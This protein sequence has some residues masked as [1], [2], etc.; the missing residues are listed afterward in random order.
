[1]KTSRRDAL[2]AALGATS[3]ALLGGCKPLARLSRPDERLAELPKVEVDPL[4]RLAN[5]I[6][7]GPRPGDLSLINSL[8]HAEFIRRQL[9]A[10][11]EEDLDVKVQLGR[12]DIYSVAAKELEDLPEAEIISQLHHGAIYRAVFSKNQLHERMVDFWTNHFNLYAKKG[13]TAYRV[14]GDQLAVIRAN[15]LGSFPKMLAAS[16]HSPAMLAYLDNQVNRKGVA[17]ENYAREIMELHSLGVNGGYTLRDVQEVARCF[18]GWTIENRFLHPRGRFRFDPDAHDNGKKL[19]L[20]QIIG[21]GGGKAD[22]DRVLSVLSSH[23]ATARHIAGKLCRHFLGDS[24]GSWPETLAE[25]YLNG[26]AGEVGN[27]HAMLEPLLNSDELL[28]AEPILK[29]PFDYMVSAL[30]ATRTRIVNTRGLQNH[31]EK[32][33]QPLHQWPMPDGYPDRTAAWTGSLLERWNFAA[34]LSGNSVAGCDVPDLDKKD[35]NLS[36]AFGHREGSALASEIEA[37]AGSDT[38]VQLFAWLASP[39]FQWR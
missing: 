25:I 13:L 31:L 22:G 28:R 12:L 21:P 10:R 16:A 37:A 19:V 27:I 18:T 5:R 2:K 17:N 6:G 20:G 38:D 34:A 30:R 39:E 36:H 15:A 32:M 29:R 1:M 23:P 3:V 35:A 9:D 33:G 7:F 26:P 14:P 11:E 24:V 4:Y 8:G